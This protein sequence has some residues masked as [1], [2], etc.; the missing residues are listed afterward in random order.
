MKT[1]FVKIS[2]ATQ[3]HMCKVAINNEDEA[4]HDIERDASM[5]AT[6]IDT[7]VRCIPCYRKTAAEFYHRIHKGGQTLWNVNSRR[8]ADEI[9]DL[10][11]AEV[12]SIPTQNP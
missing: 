9:G 4:V 10:L 8:L 12:D 5:P 6:V 2:K 11:Q 7:Y 3:C 1:Q